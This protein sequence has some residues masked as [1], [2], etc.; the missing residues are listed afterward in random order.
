MGTALAATRAGIGLGVHDCFVADRDPD[1]VRLLPQHIQ[2]RMEAWLVTHSDVRRSAR[3]RAVL[4][5]MAA[6]FAEDQGRLQG[7][8][9]A[10]AA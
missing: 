1:L 6:A 2:H 9:M 8:T 7:E 10:L 3:V 4:D 5:F